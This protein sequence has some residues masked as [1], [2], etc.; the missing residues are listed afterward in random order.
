MNLLEEDGSPGDEV[1]DFTHILD[2]L[3]D[4]PAESSVMVY[5]IT[6]K[7]GK[8]Y[9][10]TLPLSEFTAPIFLKE[11]RDRWGGG[12]YGF[13]FLDA[14]GKWIP[15][16][17]NVT[18]AQV[19]VR[20]AS[21][22]SPSSSSSESRIEE[23]LLKLLELQ[24]RPQA[25]SSPLA[26]L[27]SVMAA[28]V[29]ASATQATS[30]LEIMSKG[31][32]GGNSQGSSLKD[33]LEV[34]QAVREMN[35][36]LSDAPESSPLAALFA[37]LIPILTRAMDNNPQGGE[38]VQGEAAGAPRQI[39]AVLPSSPFDVFEPYIAHLLGAADRGDV[40]DTWAPIVELQAP[41]IV[42]LILQLH[43]V[44]GD[45]GFYSQLFQRFPEAGNRGNWIR[46]FVQL[47]SEGAEEEENSR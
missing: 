24:A 32:R 44:H 7:G 42:D 46:R 17:R 22:S 23:L 33:M 9:L 38:I 8:E 16:G 11:V 6:P 27:E 40:P 12:R 1:E 10:D 19:P 14:N 39:P 2:T 34:F 3:N 26:G 45:E 35:G 30:L 13:R 20:S 28:M 25:P 29:T 4:L 21:N 37:P 15:G 18:I 5:R 36:N 47:L 43:E 41:Q 31:N